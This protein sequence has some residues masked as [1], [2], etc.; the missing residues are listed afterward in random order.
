MT[1][2]GRIVMAL[3]GSILAFLLVL[4]AMGAWWWTAHR[5]DLQQDAQIATSEGMRFGE[6]S[7]EAGC[8]DQALMR[9]DACQNFSCQL[10]NNLFLSACLE[11]ASS[12]SEFCIG[13][14]TKDELLQTALWRQ[15]VCAQRD[16]P[17]SFCQALMNQVQ[18]HCQ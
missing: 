11:T 12:S 6:T 14:P 3:V 17:G 5:S 4:A 18:A 8:L 10:G 7:N 1:R 9:Y 13:V 2:T 15:Q 16:R